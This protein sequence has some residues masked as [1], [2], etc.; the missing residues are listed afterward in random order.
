MK[1]QVYQLL[2]K[3][4]LAT[5]TQQD[6]ANICRAFQECVTDILVT[7]LQWA[8]QAFGARTVGLV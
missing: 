8:A 1:S 6:I 4:P 5:L 3:H 2:Q 7:K